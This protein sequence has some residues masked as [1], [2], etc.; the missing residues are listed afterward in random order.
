MSSNAKKLKT[1]PVSIPA[2]LNRTLATTLDLKLQTKQAHWNVKGDN[3]IALH[4][5]FDRVAT[6]VEA[7]SDLQAERALQLD[8]SAQGSAQDIAKHSILP[9]F[10]AGLQDGAKCVK[11]LSAALRKTA[12]LAR[13]AIDT[14][15]EQGDAVTADMYTQIASGL[16]KQRWFVDAHQK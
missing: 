8:A 10:P 16:D 4:E 5:L 14:A 3:F 2:L 6:E 11:A 15:T 12:D 7:F 1:Q 9:A 13:A